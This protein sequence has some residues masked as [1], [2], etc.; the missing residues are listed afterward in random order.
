MKSS[1]KA[2][3]KNRENRGGILKK[4]IRTIHKFKLAKKQEVLRGRE[5]DLAM[6]RGLGYMEKENLPE[7]PLGC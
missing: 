2:E 5:L 7:T 6:E 4:E 3:Q 1:G